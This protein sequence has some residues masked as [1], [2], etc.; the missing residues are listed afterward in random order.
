MS[1]KPKSMSFFFVLVLS[2]TCLGAFAQEVVTTPGQANL[3]IKLTNSE[4][5]IVTFL[6]DHP[7]QTVWWPD[8]ELPIRLYRLGESETAA[9]AAYEP[10]ATHPD[11]LATKVML[12]D[13]PPTGMTF[14]VEVE[15]LLF[16]G[17]AQ[18][19]VGTET[20]A[21]AARIMCGPVLQ[22]ADDG[23][24][25]DCEVSECAALLKLNVSI[26]GDAADL[27]GLDNTIPMQ[28]S[29]VA[30]VE[31]LFSS[32]QFTRQA[33]SDNVTF[34]VDTLRDG[35]DEIQI[36]VRGDDSRVRVM[37][38]CSAT[39][40]D[41]ETGFVLLPG[42]R[43][44]PLGYTI[45]V[46]P[47]CDDITAIDVP[48]PVERTAGVLNG[49]FDVSGRTETATEVFFEHNAIWFAVHP[50]IVPA[51][52]E[53]DPEDPWIFEGAPSTTPTSLHDVG[54]R[55]LIDDG[56][57][58]LELP[59]RRHLNTGVE[60]VT[61]GVTCLGSTFVAM[62]HPL[63]GEVVL[64]DRAAGLGLDTLKTEPFT[65]LSSYYWYS[66]FI[67]ADGLPGM[68]VPG[69]SGIGGLSR[70]I[71]QG[72]YDA[73]EGKSYLSYELLLAGLG[74]ECCPLNG[75]DCGPL[76][77]RGAA[78][79]PWQ[80]KTLH[81]YFDDPASEAWQQLRTEIGV[82][83]PRTTSAIPPIGDLV[84]LEPVPE[85]HLC[86]GRVSVTFRTDPEFATLYSPRLSAWHSGWILTTPDDPYSI[87]EL[88]R[89]Y[90]LGTPT[91]ID[92][93]AG[94][95]TVSLLLPAGA[96]YWIYPSVWLASPDGSTSNSV[97]FGSIELPIGGNLE[98]G[99]DAGV[100][101]GSVTA[102][103]EIASLAMGVTPSVPSCDL[104][105]NLAFDVIFEAVAP[106]TSL[107]LQIDSEPEQT[108]CNPSPCP[109]IDGTSVP[110]PVTATLP[111]DDTYHTLKLKA[112]DE[113]GCTANLQM[114]VYVPS[115][116]LTLECV[117]DFTCTV[118]VMSI[119]LAA[120]HCCITDNLGD[121]QV[122]GGCDY[123][124]DVFDDRPSM[125]PEGSTG[126]TFTA[127][128]G[129]AT[130]TTTVTVEPAPDYQLAYA[131]G[132]RVKVRTLGTGLYQL[133]QIVPAEVTWLEFNSTG[134]RLGA[135]LAR[136]NPAVQV[137]HVDSD[138][139]DYQ[140][141]SHP[142][143]RNIAFHPFNPTDFAV[144]FGSPTAPRYW[145]AFFREDNQMMLRPMP[146]EPHM[147][148]PE[149][150]WHPNGKWLQAVSAAPNVDAVGAPTDGHNIHLYDW[151]VFVS[152]FD[153]PS[154]WEQE[155][156][157][158][159]LE[160]PFQLRYLDSPAVGVF[161][162]TLGLSLAGSATLSFVAQIDND[163]MDM[164]SDGELAAFVTTEPSGV[165]VSVIKSP[166]VSPPLIDEGPTFP[167]P[168]GFSP[169]VEMS[170]D[171]RRIAVSLGDRIEVLAYPDFTPIGTFDATD[172][173]HMRFRPKADDG[174]GC[175]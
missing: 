111:A 52:S 163:H 65:S 90:S 148:R 94:E 91:S 118:P 104:T 9:M 80:V 3:E 117:P 51:G 1:L 102:S 159:P 173:Q 31:E 37:V 114:S 107:T 57:R 84:P 152:G 95:A 45:Q 131:E 109:M 18:Y 47:S 150:A 44:T 58:Y 15:K 85:L 141:A 138:S 5:E 6:S 161:A 69:K 53:P 12:P 33:R 24:G 145:I 76:N 63:T 25:L 71:L 88:E 46:T 87:Y 81:F 133:N 155:R 164:S 66:S 166:T 11:P 13:V 79:T 151:D 103:G 10:S 142:E 38:S 127:S 175:E 121:P 143:G 156:T 110:V 75:D 168:V 162:S 116:E 157:G 48:L 146:R 23:D 42:S 170:D 78:P 169:R 122:I 68:A 73:N 123:A 59:H 165:K 106:V 35:T 19:R 128:P 92:D 7:V 34:D 60:V 93:R 101:C 119:P 54:A 20:A 55:A 129:E 70:S 83:L 26:T 115:Q 2:L 62:P 108:L 16:Q 67:S 97:W 171:G 82:L 8:E 21:A 120:T 112:E 126:V 137:F 147:S 39:V 36:L 105:G 124:V 144:V 154:T 99:A 100:V 96:Q 43:R 167:N 135:A 86:L 56:F 32:G 89:A 77:G 29:A 49:L 22:L 50:T 14:L 130:C 27:D 153:D 134:G 64:E 139:L 113:L 98:C 30:S 41:G 172:V 61:E 28:C 40:K 136:A 149:I 72:S 132:D 125:F 4:P 17:G 74:D 158:Y 160:E 140:I 174:G